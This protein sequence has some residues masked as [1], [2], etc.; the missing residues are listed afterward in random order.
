MSNSSYYEYTNNLYLDV[1]RV[2]IDKENYVYFI[3][4]FVKNIRSFSS[5]YG[6]NCSISYAASNIIGVPNRFPEHGDFVQTFAM[7]NIFPDIIYYYPI[8]SNCKLTLL[9]HEFPK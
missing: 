6:R 5:Q 9:K 1:E 8:E 3:Q 4:Q 7:V 2:D